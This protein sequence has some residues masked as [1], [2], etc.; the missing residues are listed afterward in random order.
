MENKIHSS[1]HALKVSYALSFA[2]HFGFLVA[3]F[4][5]LFVVLG[6]W[7]D[8]YFSTGHIFLASGAV[9]GVIFSNVA[10]YFLLK[11]LIRHENRT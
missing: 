9:A 10:A 11:P 3:A 2:R 5:S 1:P 7:S 6:Y 8:E 4:V